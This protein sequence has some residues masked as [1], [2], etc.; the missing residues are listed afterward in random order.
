M[1]APIALTFPYS[2]SYSFQFKINQ[3]NLIVNNEFHVVSFN[4]SLVQVI[5][6]NEG[7]NLFRFGPPGNQYI[8]NYQNCTNPLGSNYS[9]L[10]AFITALQNLLSGTLSSSSSSGTESTNGNLTVTGNLTVDGTSTLTG[11]VS[12]GNGLTVNGIS[13]TPLTGSGNFSVS[14]AYSGTWGSGW[15]IIGPIVILTI[16]GD[17]GQAN[18]SDSTTSK[19]SIILDLPSAILPTSPSEYMFDIPVLNAGSYTRGTLVIQ[20]Q[21]TY[22][23]QLYV[24]EL[25]G[26]TLST[27]TTPST[28]GMIGNFTIVYPIS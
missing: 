14:G 20:Q 3:V 27:S 4:S 12:I 21:N 19:A 15:I 16:M 26:F 7:S 17:N 18:T 9:T 13:L 23:V 28:I 11:A 8:L 5:P 1:S 2:G 10:S 6:S 24:G 25:Q 22:P